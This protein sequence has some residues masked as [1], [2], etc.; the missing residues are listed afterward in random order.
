MA[1]QQIRIGVKVDA[2]SASA[3]V[4]KLGAGAERTAQGFADIEKRAKAAGDQVARLVKLLSE[5][6]RS[7][8]DDVSAVIA[9]SRFMALQRI[10]P[11]LRAHR[12]LDD[13]L[14]GPGA[15]LRSQ[16]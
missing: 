7:R 11:A 8:V 9:N 14:T 15:A 2:G 4:D 12:G 16:T 3:A 13:Y 5:A 6:T 1:D 10:S